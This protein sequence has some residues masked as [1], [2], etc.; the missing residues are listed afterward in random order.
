MSEC[1]ICGRKCHA[2]REF[3]QYH[4][5]ANE[6]ITNSFEVWKSAMEISWND[7]LARLCEE[8]NL[9][10]FARDVVEFLMQP[11]GSSE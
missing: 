7:Y 3:C 5:L 2:E 9:G 1:Q 6:N 11:D 4:Q 10:K 8:D